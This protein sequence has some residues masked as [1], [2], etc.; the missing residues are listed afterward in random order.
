MTE[1]S[2][3][4]DWQPHIQVI[5]RP[6]KALKAFVESEELLCLRQ[7]A[8]DSKMSTGSPLGISSSNGILSVIDCNSRNK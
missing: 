4:Y 8:D 7:T 3:K 6:G 5:G 1:K 2:F